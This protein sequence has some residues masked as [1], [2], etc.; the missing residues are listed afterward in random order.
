MLL[1]EWNNVK[2]EIDFIK[3]EFEEREIKLAVQIENY[4]AR[5]EDVVAYSINDQID[6]TFKKYSNVVR[7]F[8]KY[9]NDEDLST[10][11]DQK[12][13]KTIIDDLRK[14]MANINEFYQLKHMVEDF[15]DKVKHLAVYTSELSYMLVPESS[16][17][18]DQHDRREHNKKR[19]AII[20]QGRI[21]TKWINGAKAY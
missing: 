5:I 18:G 9:F 17:L 19:D 3:N 4:K 15:Q 1:T 2:K 8:K 11:I 20:E 6:N 21:I 13:D 7:N 16:N 12:A 14:T 10:T